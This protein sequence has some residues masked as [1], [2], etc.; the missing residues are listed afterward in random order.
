MLDTTK[1]IDDIRSN[2]GK[3]NIDTTGRSIGLSGTWYGVNGVYVDTQ[4]QRSWY[5]TD[6]S[7][8]GV[9]AGKVNGVDGDGYSA[10]IEVGKEIALNDTLNIVPQAQLIYAN[11][12]SDK[13]TGANSEVVKLSTSKSLRARLGA[14]LNKLL[15]PGGATHGFVLANVIREFEDETQVNV[16]GTQLTNAVDRWTGEF[17]CRCQ[18]C[19]DQRCDSV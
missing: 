2:A 17:G 19:L 3:S 16:S 13:F 18:S 4:I 7:A 1:Q 6:L 10:S 14:S 5:D 11:V 12:D 15:T 9:G 8:G